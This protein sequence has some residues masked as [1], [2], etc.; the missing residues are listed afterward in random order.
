MDGGTLSRSVGETQDHI[1]FKEMEFFSTSS[2][3]S[4]QEAIQEMQADLRQ[5][6]TPAVRLVSE[7]IQTAMAK[8]ASDI[9][10][11]PRAAETAVRI[12]VDGVLRDLR[13]IPRNLQISLISR[14]KILA[15]MDISERRA[16]QDGRFMV[17]VGQRQIDLRVSSLPTQY[18]EK[19]VMRLLETS[20][21]LASFADMGMPLDISRAF[22]ELL[23]L[24][25]GMILVTGP[26][27]SGKS[28]TIYSSSTQIA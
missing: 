23:S 5:R 27:G 15:D 26:T 11:E 14:I 20:A 25:Q 12:R 7:I 22:S 19:I 10:I 1:T 9:H 28:T 6:K 18:G 3:Q 21:P 16:P 2:R 24:P 17:A 8:N 13:S 4:N